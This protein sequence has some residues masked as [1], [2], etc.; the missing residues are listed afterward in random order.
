MAGTE[1]ARR[2]RPN[3]TF[4]VVLARPTAPDKLTT[5]RVRVT[6][7]PRSFSLPIHVSDR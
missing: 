7:R 3:R 5:Y 6:N 1:P 2:T 4:D